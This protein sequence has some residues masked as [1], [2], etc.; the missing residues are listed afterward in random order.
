MRF[1]I[2]LLLFYLWLRVVYVSDPQPNPTHPDD[3][4]FEDLK[5]FCL[6]GLFW[7]PRDHIP[8]LLF[9]VGVNSLQV[10]FVLVIYPI[11]FLSSLVFTGFLV[12]HPAE[13]A[14]LLLLLVQIHCLSVDIFKNV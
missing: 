11:A 10:N 7:I 2:L 13:L 14:C 4:V 3:R 6:K 12:H 8:Q 5:T 1:L 9:W